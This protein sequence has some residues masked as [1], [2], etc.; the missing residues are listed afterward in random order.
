MHLGNII[1][2]LMLAFILIDLVWIIVRNIMVATLCNFLIHWFTFIQFIQIIQIKKFH[3]KVWL[4]GL[5]SPMK[6][7]A[8]ISTIALEWSQVSSKQPVT[9]VHSAHNTKCSQ[10]GEIDSPPW[11][12]LRLDVQPKSLKLRPIICQL[13][14]IGAIRA[15]FVIWFLAPP[16]HVCWF[17]WW[18]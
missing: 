3:F 18:F 7:I 8:N 6:S 4:V 9:K 12:Q 1:K 14:L 16:N 10:H 15:W 5:I 13:L 2:K 11:T 17:G